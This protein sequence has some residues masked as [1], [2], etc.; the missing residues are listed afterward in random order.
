M[1]WTAMLHALGSCSA[2]HI[3]TCRSHIFVYTTESMTRCVSLGYS[4]ISRHLRKLVSPVLM[5]YA[6]A[7]ET[8]QMHTH[9]CSNPS[10]PLGTTL[11][12]WQQRIFWA[13]CLADCEAYSSLEFINIYSLQLCTFMLCCKVYLGRVKMSPINNLKPLQHTHW[14]HFVHAHYFY[15]ISYYYFYRWKRKKF[16]LS[17]CCRSTK[18]LQGGPGGGS[19]G[20][21]ETGEKNWISDFKRN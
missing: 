6:A 7:L 16:L 12:W 18:T 10:S 9:R 2:M 3:C 14:K 5:S 21:P 19:T 15:I 13:P 17:V 20:K 1:W 8:F 4:L 11:C